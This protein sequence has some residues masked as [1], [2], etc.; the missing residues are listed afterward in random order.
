VVN[1]AKVAD[2]D[3]DGV[4]MREIA[5]DLGISAA[6]ICRIVKRNDAAA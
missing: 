4:T 3:A 6:S 1:R 5:E 2:M